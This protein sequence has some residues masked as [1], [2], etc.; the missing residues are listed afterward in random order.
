MSDK[1]TP[2]PWSARYHDGCETREMGPCEVVADGC[3]V[4]RLDCGIY[5]QRPDAEYMLR[6][7]NAHDELVAALRQ[8][9]DCVNVNGKPCSDCRRLA[10]AALAKVAP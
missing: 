7:V 8:T 3:V 5:M 2:R 9:M 6:A 1:T 10:R 4:I